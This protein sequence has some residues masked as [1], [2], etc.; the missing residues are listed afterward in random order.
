[1]KRTAKFFLLFIV[2]TICP[3]L[4]HA[5]GFRIEG[6]SSAPAAG[7]ETFTSLDGRFAIALPKQISGYSPQSLNTS[8]GRLEIVRYDWRTADGVF[9]IAYAD[10]T[11]NLEN[12][13]QKVIDGARDG[14]L[15]SSEGKA[16]LIS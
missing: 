13:S 8:G 15:A 10:R 5:Q 6:S 1:M 4:L 12:I 7:S 9:I 16:K 3:A 11:E 14:I 2:L